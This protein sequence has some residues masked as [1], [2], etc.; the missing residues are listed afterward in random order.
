MN[1]KI[2]RYLKKVFSGLY[3][4]RLHRIRMNTLK[5]TER[6]KLIPE[7]EYPALL[8]AI[9]KERI[10]HELDWHNLNT[11]T[12]K[13]QW[14]KLY[15]KNPMKPVLSDKFA[16]REWVQEKIGA[17]YLIPLLGVWDSYDEIDFNSLPNQFVLKTNHGSG[18]N[19]IVKNKKK[20]NMRRTKKMFDVWMKTDYAFVSDFE[21]HYSLIKP[22]IIAEKYME[23]GNNELPDYKFI[24]FGGNPYFCQVD[25]GRYGD[26]TR[27]IFDTNWNLQDWNRGY[28]KH[29]LEPVQKP[30]NFEKML[31]LAKKLAAGF[32]HVRVDFYNVDGNI[33]FGEM[34]FTS[35]SGLI[36]FVPESADLILGKMWNLD[37]K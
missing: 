19:L 4:Y 31:E 3:E 15:D 11:Y 13:M 20:L 17:E 33:Y 36:P 16:V 8:A 2:K 37:T 5:E 28:V 12:E 27:D 7:K 26:H 22:R 35:A 21:M 30:K 6:M 14:E 9:Y 29:S 32:S 10:G 23:T 18:T 1:D 24:C 25:Q 34:T